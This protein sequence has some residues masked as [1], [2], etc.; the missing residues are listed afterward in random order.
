LKLPAEGRTGRAPGLNQFIPKPGKRHREIWEELW[1]TPQ[2][3]AWAKERWLWPTVADLVRAMVRNEDP[4]AKA[5]FATTVR[6]L[7]DELGL[8]R[9]GLRVNGWEISHDEV[10]AKREERQGTKAAA[11]APLPRRLAP[12]A[13]K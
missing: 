9:A 10:A 3:C 4:D 12:P 2:A 13:A 7:R 8:S 11:P 5:A 6:Q 1:R